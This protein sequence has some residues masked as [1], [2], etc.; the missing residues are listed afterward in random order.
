MS[1]PHPR[2]DAELPCPWPDCAEGTPQQTL[3]ILHGSEAAV[4]A[5]RDRSL[6]IEAD[7]GAEMFRRR[8]TAGGWEWVRS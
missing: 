3:V 1:C 2:A 6:K 4:T 7:E 8:Q 5:V